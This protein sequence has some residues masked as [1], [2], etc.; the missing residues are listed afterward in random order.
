MIFDLGKEEDG[1]N[2]EAHPDA[3]YVDLDSAAGEDRVLPQFTGDDDPVLKDVPHIEKS[4][5]PIVFIEVDS[6]VRNDIVTSVFGIFM[7]LATH[8]CEEQH[9]VFIPATTDAGGSASNV[10]SG[11]DSGDIGEL[12]KQAMEW[13]TSHVDVG[14]DVELTN[15]KSCHMASLRISIIN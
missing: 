2:E 11:R 3:V 1:P 8:R 7:L 4:K 10:K 15:V 9:R 13:L 14:P 12:Q 6:V 5:D